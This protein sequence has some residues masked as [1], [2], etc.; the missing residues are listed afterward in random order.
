MGA[1]EW[2]KDVDPERHIHYVDKNATGNN[3]GTTWEN[4]FPSLQTALDN[5]SAGDE[6]WVAKGTYK[7][8]SA[9][10]LTNTPRYYHFE[11]K[12]QRKNQYQIGFQLIDKNKT[13]HIILKNFKYL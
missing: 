10:T 7:P 9:Y 3:N 6:I 12:S 2:T 13:D 4:A 8:S 5:A 11:L 1:Y